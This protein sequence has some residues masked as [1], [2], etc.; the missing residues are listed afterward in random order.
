MGLICRFWSHFDHFWRKWRDLKNSRADEIDDNAWINK[1]FGTL[2]RLNDL[3]PRYWTKTEPI[4]SDDVTT[5]PAKST[6]FISK[7]KSWFPMLKNDSKSDIFGKFLFIVG[8]R[9]RLNSFD[10]VWSGLILFIPV[11][12]G[13]QTKK[14][15]KIWKFSN[16]LNQKF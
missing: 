6:L 2:N 11:I 13:L 8:I 4:L 10:L 7:S 12:V 3:K 14:L 5:M 9:R 15:A 16:F 1:I